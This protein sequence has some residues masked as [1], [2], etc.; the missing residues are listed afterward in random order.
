MH[1]CMNGVFS[2][3]NYF[4]PHQDKEAFFGLSHFFKIVEPQKKK[5][6][7]VGRVECQTRVIFFSE[8]VFGGDPFFGPQKKLCTQNGPAKKQ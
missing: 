1:W 3:C 8:F 2:I 4:F 6:V 7:T 5:V